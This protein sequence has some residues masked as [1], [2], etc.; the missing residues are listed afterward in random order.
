LIHKNKILSPNHLP[1]RISIL[2]PFHN[3]FKEQKMTTFE[4]LFSPINIKNMELPNRCVMPPMATNLCNRDLTVSDANIA[5]LDRRA[6]GGV[7]LIITEI[8]GIHPSGTVGIGAYED[9]FMAGLEKMADVIH[10]NGVKAAA[11]LHHAGR[12]AYY[13]LNKGE[14]L[15]PSA[16]PGPVVKIPPKEMTTD[17][18]KMI[19]AAFGQAAL[20]ARQ[21]GFDAVEIHGAHGY[22]ISQFFSALSNHRTDEYGGD[23]K[24]RSRFAMEVVEEIKNCVGDDFP[25][26]FRISAEE[27]IKN[28]YT[29]EDVQQI[30]PDLVKSGV[31]IIHASIGT[32]GSPGGI[33]CATPEYEEGF[34]AWR[35]E[36]LKE[37]VDVPV[38][39][40]GRF[41]NP[42]VADAAIAGG[43]ADMI[44]FGRQ[45]L[46]DPDFLM[47]A[48]EGRIDDIRKCLACNQGCI[49]RLMMGKN[50]SV[51]CAINPE[52]G[53]ELIYPEKPAASKKTVWVIGAG[54]AG[55]TAASEAARLG[56][57]VTVYEKDN[58]IGGQ[59]RFAAKAPVKGLYGDWVKWL[60]RHL[61]TT[62]V[63]LKTDITVTEKVLLEGNA[64]VVISAI[65]AESI[66]PDIPG[67]DHKMVCNAF[68]ILDGTIP[69][70]KQ[71]VVI[72]GGLI[73]ME[74]AD[75]L[76]EKG[77]T[78]TIVE[79]LP[80]SPVRKATNHGYHLH[81]RLA[82]GGCR[83]LLN[84]KVERIQDNAVEISSKEN[85][86]IISPVDQVVIAAGMKSR[87]DLKKVLGDKG[88]VHHVVGDALNPRRIVEAVEEGA[89]AAWDI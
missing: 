76:S 69:P 16:I 4:H 61:D 38:I 89:K 6:K 54:P 30:L 63:I 46:A 24:S 59:V 1:S 13:Q 88:I 43:Q 11:Q 67:I 5:Y 74:V 77:S 80:R 44:A 57:D 20:R 35:A 39:A 68:E 87:Q 64:D 33:G 15:A 66:I 27:Y 12:E 34:N 26:S 23:F 53:Q 55:L 62:G 60:E 3:H 70:G 83:I 51:R 9:R 37:V 45:L 84:T 40:V 52:T 28:G 2:N 82:E 49:E 42:S 72:G 17:D 58:E 10:K 36:K 7:G 65:G 31:D 19:V 85:K 14:A 86:E 25:I 50:S 71:L 56:H 75:F 73:G 32:Y 41:S 21:A 22:L 78:V 48:K 79:I 29:V 81:K 47:K 8:V 18:I